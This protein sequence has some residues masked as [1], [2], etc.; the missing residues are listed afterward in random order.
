MVNAQKAVRIAALVALWL[1]T[2]LAALT[3]GKAG[4]GKFADAAGWQFWF[5]KWGFAPWFATVIGLA[6]LGG[7]ALLLIP[8]LAPYAA[9]LLMA[10]MLGA[11]YTVTTNVTDLSAVDPIINLVLLSIVLIGRWPRGFRPRKTG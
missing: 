8:K 6:E 7:A 2:V 10:I 9:T 11:F 3:L 5:Q 4:Y 1:V